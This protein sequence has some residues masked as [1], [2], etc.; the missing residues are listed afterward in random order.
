MV[1][2]LSHFFLNVLFCF[3]F[4][5]SLLCCH[6]CYKFTLSRYIPVKLNLKKVML[7]YYVSRKRCLCLFPLLIFLIKSIVTLI[8]PAAQ[9]SLTEIRRKP[10]LKTTLHQKICT[11]TMCTRQACFPPFSIMI[12]HM[13]YIQQYHQ[14]LAQKAV[15]DG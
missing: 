2:Q 1:C 15:A 3:G 6:C 7:L 14:F 5:K 10:S 11:V 4:F 12:S 13:P 8:P 9:K